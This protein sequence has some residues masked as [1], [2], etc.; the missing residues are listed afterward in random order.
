MICHIKDTQIYYEVIGDGIPVVNI[1][2]YE[3]DHRAMKGCLEPIFLSNPDYDQSYQRIYFDLPGMG[4][5]GTNGSIQ[6]SD[7]ML[8]MVLEFIELVTGGRD[9]ILTGL[10]YGGLLARGVLHKLFSR[11]KGL[12]LLC[13]VIDFD[14]T[15]RE[16][17]DYR[18][19][20]KDEALVSRLTKEQL[21][22]IDQF[23]VVQT[24]PVWDRY[25]KEI[26]P[27][28]FLPDQDLIER[29][30]NTDF[31]FEVDRLEEPFDQ[32]ALILLGRYDVSVGYKDAWRIYENFSNGT[33]AVVNNAGHCLQME[34]PDLFNAHMSAW[35]DQIEMIS[36]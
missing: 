29:I 32:P 20:E 14:R 22:S 7:D 33:L 16:L 2:G 17:P 31:S 6:N 9:F 11:L 15:K 13:P 8:E 21:L 3:I 28:V 36:E 30:R 12:M 18:L 10:S 34:Q 25:E 19:F 26:F 4:H 1:H 27:A 35:L 24:Q 23:V 5:S